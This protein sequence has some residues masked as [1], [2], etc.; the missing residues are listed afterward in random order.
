MGGANY[1]QGSSR[2][3]AALAPRRLGLRLVLAKSFSR[4]HRQNL[5]NFGVLPLTFIQQADYDSI[6]QGD[7]LVLRRLREQ[8]SAAGPIHVDMKD[9][10]LELCARLSPRERDVLVSG[11]LIQHRK[12]QLSGQV[13]GQPAS[14]TIPQL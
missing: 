9:R 10:R 5:V 11:G 14:D 13:R 3:H 2:E 12:Q 4:I 8:L 1:G 7:V 6:Q